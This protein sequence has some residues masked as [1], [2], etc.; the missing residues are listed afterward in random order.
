MAQ[1]QFV[2]FGD[3]VTWG[4]GLADPHKFSSLVR[5]SLAAAGREL[6]IEMLAHSGATIGYRGPD[7]VPHI[8]GEVPVASPTVFKQ[9]LTYSG[10]PTAAAVVLVTGGINDVN[11]RLLLNPLTPFDEVHYKTQLYCYHDM[12]ALLTSTTQLFTSPTTKIVVTA[13]FPFLSSDS[14]PLRAPLLLAAHGVAPAPFAFHDIVF[15]KLVKLSMQFWNES[16]DAL[17]RAVKD[18]GDSRVVLAVAP[19]TEKNSVYATDPWL[20]GLNA[21]DFSPQDEVIL[22]RRQACDLRYPPIDVIDREACYRA[23]AG[24]PNVTG[25]QRFADVILSVL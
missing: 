25:A 19:F 11:V 2:V 5:Q 18:C 9:L 22:E 20:F 4:Q 21:G 17:R 16:T 12:L 3:S 8:D 1:T 10:D 6:T 15:D 13:Y 14:N 7:D 24:H 23:S